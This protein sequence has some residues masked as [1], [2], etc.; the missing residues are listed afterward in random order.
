MRCSAC[1]TENEAG[2]KF[3]GECGRALVHTCPACN[4]PNPPTVKFCGECGTALAARTVESAPAPTAERRLVTVLFADHVG[5]TAIAEGRDAEE[6]REL[7]S[8]YFE[9]ARRLIGRY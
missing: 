1:G 9:T 5:F 3:C 8:Q 6:T 7:L 4:T 2:R